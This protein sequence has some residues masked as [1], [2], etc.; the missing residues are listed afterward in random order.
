MK[1]THRQEIFFYRLLDL[2][3]ESKG[4]IHYSTLA[5]RVGVSPFTAYD[6][7]RLLEEKGFVTSEY[8]IEA[9]KSTVGRSEIVFLPTQLA[10]NRFAEL[11]NGAD[12]SN[13]EEVKSQIMERI[14]AGDI[15][16]HELADDLITRVPLDAPDSLRYCFEVMTLLVLRLGKNTGRKVLVERMPQILGWKESFSKSGLIIL[17]GFILGLLAMDNSLLLDRDQPILEYVQKYQSLISKMEPRLANRL[18]NNIYDMFSLVL[19]V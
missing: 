8:R 13:W 18:A 3:R 16:D 12:L 6:M 2:Y 17:G 7:L 4:P 9:G 19:K 14:L 15:R 1:L 11:A 5:E 10:D